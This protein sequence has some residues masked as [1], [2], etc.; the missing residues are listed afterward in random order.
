LVP[1]KFS[2]EG[3]RGH[4][5]KEIIIKRGKGSRKVD[6]MFRRVVIDGQKRAHALPIRVQRKMKYGPR[7]ASEA[8]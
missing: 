6:K 3:T 4:V 7:I 1:L 2:G 8:Y 5:L